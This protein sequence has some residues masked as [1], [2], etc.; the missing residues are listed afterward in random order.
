MPDGSSEILYLLPYLSLHVRNPPR[1]SL[2]NSTFPLR[3]FLARL[4]LLNQLA[5]FNFF[6]YTTPV[7]KRYNP[8]IFIL[9]ARFLSAVVEIGPITHPDASHPSTVLLPFWSSLTTEY[10]TCHF[11]ACS[12][13]LQALPLALVISVGY[14]CQWSG[15]SA[16][17]SSQEFHSQHIKVPWTTLYSNFLPHRTNLCL[18]ASRMF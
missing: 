2:Y 15:L 13:T 7:C 11:K 16:Q 18:V 9:S 14:C 3:I 17:Q 5:P 8:R 10:M 6:T 12:R 1:N 4:Y